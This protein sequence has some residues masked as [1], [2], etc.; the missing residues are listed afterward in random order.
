M[1]VN[2]HQRCLAFAG[3]I[4]RTDDSQW[5]CTLDFSRTTELMGEAKCTTVATV[6]S[7]AK[8]GSYRGSFRAMDT[9]GG[10]FYHSYYGLLLEI[11]GFF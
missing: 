6:A 7:P 5:T 9:V 3:A 8:G 11:L 4:T 2:I 10:K 1:I